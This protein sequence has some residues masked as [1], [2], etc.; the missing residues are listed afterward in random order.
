MVSI[1]Q[2]GQHILVEAIFLGSVAFSEVE[3]TTDI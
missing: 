1:T 2:T 3:I